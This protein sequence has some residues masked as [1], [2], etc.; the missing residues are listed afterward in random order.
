MAHAITIGVERRLNLQLPCGSVLSHELHAALS[1]FEVPF[2]PYGGGEEVTAFGPDFARASRANRAKQQ[3]PDR[4]LPQPFAVLNT[5]A[6]ATGDP[7]SLPPPPHAPGAA[8]IGDSRRAV[9][10]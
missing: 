1:A 4:P 7:G 8:A 3:R 10:V 2:D 5:G 6:A 9:A